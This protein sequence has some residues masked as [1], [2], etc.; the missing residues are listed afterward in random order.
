[1]KW[2]A[3]EV[4][5]LTN[6]EREKHGVPKLNRA[7]ASLETAAYVRAEEIS[8]V[9]G[10]TR[11][12]GTEFHTAMTEAGYTTWRSAGEN[13]AKVWP[14]SPDKGYED[15]PKMM[16]DG[17]MSSEGHKDNI[18]NPVYKILSVGVFHDNRPEAEYAIYMVQLFSD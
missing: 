15:I 17:L 6:S 5:Q 8:V 2:F 13:I 16:V 10:H 1:M 14:Y 4:Y 18:L 9:W 12:N 7:N 3:E 11:P